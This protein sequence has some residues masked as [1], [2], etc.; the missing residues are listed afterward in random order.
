[1]TFL[2][3]TTPP[4]LDISTLEKDYV[5]NEEEAEHSYNPFQLENFQRY[6]PIYSK[7]FEL[8]ETNYNKVAL[9]HKFHIRDMNTVL[10]LDENK[11]QTR[12]IFIKYSPLL[13]P[14]RYLIGKYSSTD[15]TISCVTYSDFGRKPPKTIRLQ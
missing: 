6:Q 13:D 2:Q 7:F 1:M 14:L 11:T 9:N 5:S 8:T 4:S 3:Y 12:P 15:K 10:D